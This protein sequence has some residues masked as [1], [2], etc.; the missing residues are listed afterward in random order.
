MQM[1]PEEIVEFRQEIRLKDKIDNENVKAVEADVSFNRILFKK[2][3][4]IIFHGNGKLT[5]YART[6]DKFEK[7]CESEVNME[8]GVQAF[9]ELNN[10]LIVTIH[11]YVDSPAVVSFWDVSGNDTITRVHEIESGDKYK[12]ACL[13][14]D[15][16]SNIGD[17]CFMLQNGVIF[18]VDMKDV[19]DPKI[20]QHFNSSTD[21]HR[22]CVLSDGRMVVG[23]GE[24]QGGF[25]VYKVVPPKLNTDV[26]A[27]PF[28][29]DNE[30]PYTPTDT[31][32]SL[33]DGKFAIAHG[34]DTTFYKRYEDMYKL[35]DTINGYVKKMQLLPDGGLLVKHCDADICFYRE[36]NGKW[37]LVESY[38]HVDQIRDI[39]YLG[40][41]VVLFVGQAESKDRL[42]AFDLFVWNSN[43]HKL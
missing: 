11:W 18:P 2:K 13:I 7:I 20:G 21:T 16:I 6:G 22:M 28:Q 27:Y 39:T 38:Q 14:K 33:G 9:R 43:Y 17:E 35:Y 37:E 24:N 12:E 34:S 8:G 31:I 10:G 5:K 30:K 1:T 29:Y 32:C 19:N 25:H 23:F 15:F 36:K 41:G 3:G 4:E 42:D 40:E 26:L